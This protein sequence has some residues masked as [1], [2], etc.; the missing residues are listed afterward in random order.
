MH[1][2]F[3]DFRKNSGKLV[4]LIVLEFYLEDF[5]ALIISHGAQDRGL[6]GL[7]FQ[8]YRQFLTRVL[9]G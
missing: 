3:I 1:E 4:N 9:N 8:K 5:F 2:I 6:N 7:S